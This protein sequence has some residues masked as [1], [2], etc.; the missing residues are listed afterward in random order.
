MTTVIAPSYALFVANNATGISIRPAIHT[1]AVGEGQGANGTFHSGAQTKKSALGCEVKTAD[2]PRIGYKSIVT[3]SN[4]TASGSQQNF[5]IREV[6]GDETYKRWKPPSLPA[7]ITIDAGS[8]VSCDYFGIGAHSL[9][10]CRITFQSS[11]D[12]SAWS[13]EAVS[14]PTDN[15]AIFGM[16]TATARYY[17]FRI[18]G[19]K[20]PYIANIRVG[21]M[22]TMPIKVKPVPII[23]NYETITTDMKSENGQFVGR[24]IIRTGIRTSAEF[25]FLKAEFT[26]NYLHDFIK[27]ARTGAFYFSWNP[28][29]YPDEAAYCWA[30]KPEAP[31]PQQKDYLSWNLNMMGFSDD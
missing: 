13:D 9:K 14:E 29:K 1:V 26:R 31:T 2:F 10:G 15:N 20:I 23:M 3:T 4:I 5:D 6:V 11:N 21:Q 22:L 12:G 27:Y 30:D 17:R 8:E 7:T 28:N 19:N 16:F 18:T 25:K 24:S